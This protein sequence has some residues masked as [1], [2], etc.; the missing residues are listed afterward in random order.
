MTIKTKAP[1]APTRHNIDR[2]THQI[3]ADSQGS[4]DD[5]LTTQQVAAWLGVSIQWVEIGRL[6]NYGPKYTR[7]TPRLIRYKR[8]D[9]LEWLNARKHSST[10]EYSR[11]VAG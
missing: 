4:N 3:I 7:L 8:S 11:R 6:R 10:A 2:R 9:V 1:A 5:L